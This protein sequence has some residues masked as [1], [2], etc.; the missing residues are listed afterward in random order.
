MHPEGSHP[1]LRLVRQLAA[2]GEVRRVTDD[3]LLRRYAR[4]RDEQA[5]EILVHR[6]GAMVWRVCCNVLRQSQAAEDAFQATFLILIRK[7]GSIGQP[8]RLANWL[9]GVAQ[10]VALRARQTIARRQ[11]RE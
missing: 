5:F 11:A 8:E 6:H 3:E 4:E 7:A 2:A 1:I 10:R 9:Y